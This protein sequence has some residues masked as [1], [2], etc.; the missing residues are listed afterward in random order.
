M[1]KAM[2]AGTFDEVRYEEIIAVLKAA[3][4]SSYIIAEE[5]IVE[6]FELP[7]NAKVKYENLSPLGISILQKDIEEV[8]N[9]LN[10]GCYISFC[11]VI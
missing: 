9:I 2:E 7:G 11:S 8:A 10:Q 3:E 5:S 1:K 4:E 6:E